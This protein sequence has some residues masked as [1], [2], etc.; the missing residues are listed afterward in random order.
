MR[1]FF[2]DITL[3]KRL[4]VIMALLVAVTICGMAV[5]GYMTSQTIIRAN[6]SEKMEAIGRLKDKRITGLLEQVDR[7]IRLRATEP[8]T[9]QAL[10]ALADGYNSLE[11]PEEVLRRVYITENEFP[12]GEKDQLV[13]A[14]TGSSYGFI[15]AIY[16]KPFDTLQNEMGYYDIFLIDPEGNLVYSVFKENDFATNL[17]TG[18]WKDSGL[19]DAFRGAL[20]IG[21][22]DP[23]VFSDFAPYEPSS[24]APA[25]FM[26]R[27]VFNDRGVLL[28]VLAYQLPVE[29]LNAAAGELEGLGSTADGFL[30]GEDRLMRT[31]SPLTE[32]DEMLTATVDN[33][34]VTQ[35]L[36]GGS[37][38]FEA[39]G[40]DGQAVLGYYSNVEFNGTN[41]V[42]IVQQDQAE[43]YSWAYW[44]LQ[45][46]AMIAVVIFGLSLVVSVFFSRSVARPVQRLTGSVKEVAEGNLQMEVPETDRGD[47]IGDLARA[48]EVFRQNSLRIEKMNEEQ[49][50]AAERMAQ[51]NAEREEAAKRE[52]QAAQERE[53]AEKASALEREEMMRQLGESFGDVVAQAL[54]GRF[55]ARVTAEF[56]D[57]ILIELARNINSLMEV[58]DT[59]LSS[60]GSV[61]EK[62]AHGDLTQRLEGAFSGSFAELQTSV[63]NMIGSLTGLI[64][65][66][67]ASGATLTGSSGELQQTADILSRQAEQ[68]AASVEQTSA[69][70]EELSASIKHVS[71]NISEVSSNAREARD[72]AVT[73]EKIA[74]DA[75][76]SMDRIADG[77]KEISRVTAV[78]NDIAFQIN[79]LA[80]NAGVEAARAGEAGR[81]FSVVASEVRQ[82]AQRASDAAKEIAEVIT[83]SDAAVSEGVENVASA[84]ASLE[85]ISGRVIRISESVDDVTT[86]INEQSSGINEINSAI[87]QI[88]AN[89]QKQAAAFEEVTASSHVLAQ[90]AKE[91]GQSTARFTIPGGQSV[92]QPAP[93]AEKVR[94][95]VEARP[96]PKVAAAPEPADGTYGGTGWEEF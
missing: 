29:A 71:G 66:I 9:S 4:P 31:D 57:E 22:D 3:A 79:L 42:M 52:A 23:T 26:S 38:V 93:K 12:A 90:E 13:K 78:I 58:V 18:P 68:N 54:S 76:A 91:L 25:A 81:G 49:K 75:A 84:K 51:M 20:E 47:E 19:A 7:D 14:D 36:D 27:P 82:L 56:N 32:A 2:R 83:Q 94:P 48:T 92:G 15:H 85:D 30:V 11:A 55:S 6:A 8:A 80:L 65:D 86:A 34:G 53:L 87:S 63:N 1:K 74:G 24:F 72:T 39:I 21:A 41:W 50:E 67:S 46:G 35:G 96:E 70:L 88:D 45:R 60:T 5:S 17:Q 37:G 33:V 64:G 10:I 40:R 43:L 77:S 95:L 73:S 69:A 16:H 89:T 44:A 28:G 61:L 59:G 62:V